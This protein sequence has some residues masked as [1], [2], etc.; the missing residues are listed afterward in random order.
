MC[1]V[2]CAGNLE[3]AKILLEHPK[4]TAQDACI[5]VRSCSYGITSS[6]YQVDRRGGYVTV[7]GTTALDI[8][9]H[10]DK[11]RDYYATESYYK[12]DYSQM[13]GTDPKTGKLVKGVKP[14]P[15]MNGSSVFQ[16]EWR[17]PFCYNNEV[18]RTRTVF[19]RRGTYAGEK[20]S[21]PRYG[22]A[23]AATFGKSAEM[24]ALLRAHGC[25]S[26]EQ[27]TADGLRAERARLQAQL[28][29]LPAAAAAAAGGGKPPPK[30]A[31]KGGG[32][33]DQLAVQQP[34]PVNPRRLDAAA[35]SVSQV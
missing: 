34:Q 30:S 24:A 28:D 4:F 18:N 35:S 2:L 12:P 1:I 27:G 33:S 19:P 25:K 29:A 26:G 13:W 16:M 32:G 20:K 21:L 17:N 8:A 5:G 9:T 23:V 3:M 10:G 7:E 31:T 14:P 22:K 6:Y 11:P 15:I